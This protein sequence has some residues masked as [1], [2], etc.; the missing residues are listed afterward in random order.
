VPNLFDDLRGHVGWA[1]T[2]RSAYH[3]FGHVA[4]AHPKIN[5]FYV[6]LG[7]QEDVLG[8]QISIK[9]VLLVEIPDSVQ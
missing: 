8:L 7:I 4:L 5:E 6:T 2:E 3:L 9:N 1:T